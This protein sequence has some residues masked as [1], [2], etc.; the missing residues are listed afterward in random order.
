MDG[1]HR[2]SGDWRVFPFSLKVSCDGNG[3][4]QTTKSFHEN[5]WTSGKNTV[6]GKTQMLGVGPSALSGSVMSDSLRPHGL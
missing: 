1:G 3:K 2:Q 5:W 6:S 4:A